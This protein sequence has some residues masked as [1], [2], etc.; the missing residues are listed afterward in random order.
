MRDEYRDL[1]IENENP[2][3]TYKIFDPVMGK[4]CR[5]GRSLYGKP[6][7]AWA[8]KAGAANALKNMP[9]DVRERVIIK[10]FSLTEITE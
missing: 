10:K 5:S 8:N 2:K 4:F 6:R 9:K 1:W 3:F 7:T